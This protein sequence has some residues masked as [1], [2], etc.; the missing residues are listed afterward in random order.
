MPEI[1]AK[2]VMKLR[3][4][5]GLP[6][7]ACKAAL[8]EADGD[9]EKA[10]DILRK[11]LKGKMETKLDRAAGEGRVAIAVDAGNA[12]IVEVRAE[13][14]FT[15]KNDRFI[16]ATDQVAQLALQ[17]PAGEIS[18]T[19]E[20]KAQVDDVRIS[21]GENASIA[22]AHK[23]EGGSGA[24]FGKYVHHDGK[25]GVLIH[26]EGDVSDETL[27]QICMHVTAAVPRPLGVSADDIPA[28]MTERERRF[29]I[30]TAMESGKPKEIAEKMVEGGMSK[31]FAE[32]ALLEQ[33]FVMDP[34]KKV[35]D[36][37]GSGKIHAFF[38]WQVGETDA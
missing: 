14:D 9:A 12:A 31:F 13:T 7:M 22:R 8:A 10:E 27:R 25:T 32:V 26:A 3:N 24:K 23:I 30:E 37:L 11:Q 5:T 20:M 6:M 35:K 21:T 36:L 34:S 28:E 2:D 1:N 19:D 17:A 38:R 16:S 4:K 18:P 33:N 15:A 29:R